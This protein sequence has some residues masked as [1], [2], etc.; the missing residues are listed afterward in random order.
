MGVDDEPRTQPAVVG[1]PEGKANAFRS[2][3]R[4]KS[5]PKANIKRLIVKYKLPF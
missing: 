5:A 2:E 4:R 1:A 3:L